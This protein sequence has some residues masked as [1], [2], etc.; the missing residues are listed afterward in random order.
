M[1]N[2]GFRVLVSPFVNG[3]AVILEFQSSSKKIRPIELKLST[4]RIGIYKASASLNKIY[5][6]QMQ[7]RSWITGEISHKQIES[8][9]RLMREKQLDSKFTTQNNGSS[10]KRE[11]LRYLNITFVNGN[12]FL[13]SKKPTSSILKNSKTSTGKTSMIS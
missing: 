7:T 9:K 3:T 2:A 4:G 6:T 13:T 5:A 1:L 8:K 12:S 11:I 10:A